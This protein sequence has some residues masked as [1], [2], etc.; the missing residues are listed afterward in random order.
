MEIKIDI[1]ELELIHAG[2]KYYVNNASEFHGQYSKPRVRDFTTK[3][4]GLIQDYN[5]QEK[6]GEE[7]GR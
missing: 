2:L 3:L 7:D 4:Y 5:Y 6:M 1:K